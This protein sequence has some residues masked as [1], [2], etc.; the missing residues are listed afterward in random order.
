MEFDNVQMTKVTKD[1]FIT[2]ESRKYQPKKEEDKNIYSNNTTLSMLPPKKKKENII[3]NE[4]SIEIKKINYPNDIE[5]Y[6]EEELVSSYSQRT[7]INK[8]N[9]SKDKQSKSIS[10]MNKSAKIKY[11]IIGSSHSKKNAFAHSKHKHSDREKF[12]KKDE[13]LLLDQSGKNIIEMKE[14]EKEIEMPSS[15]DSMTNL[16]KIINI[17]ILNDKEL[18]NNNK[19]LNSSKS[20]S[21]DISNENGIVCRVCYEP[22]N[23]EKGILINPCICTGTCKYIHESCLKKWIENN[24]AANKIKAECEICKYQYHMKFFTYLKFSKPKVCK[25]V[26]SIAGGFLVSAVILCLI[27]TVIYVVVSSLSPLSESSKKNFIVIL[28]SIACGIL[29][30]FI[31]FSLRNWKTDCYEEELNN[32]K[33][34]NIEG[35]LKIII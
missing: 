1:N 10:I 24:C 9:L 11:S 30:L 6:V 19:N 12:K 20:Q 21:K 27:L 2:E 4:N 13:V 35:K 8:N 17:P 16:N 28:V 22:D 26:K 23:E 5:E 14:N 29:L 7:S 15:K 33:I 32:W 31:L 25:L 18:D 34:Y 3:N